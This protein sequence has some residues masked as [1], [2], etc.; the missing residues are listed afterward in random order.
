MT[1]LSKVFFGKKAVISS[2]INENKITI[3]RKIVYKD[4]TLHESRNSPKENYWQLI[5]C[6]KILK[7]VINFEKS[8]LG[9]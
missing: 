8:D 5:K 7:K 1:T 6:V 3:L 9:S 4:Q 2:L